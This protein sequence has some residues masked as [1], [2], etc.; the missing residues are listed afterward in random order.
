M[1]IN[2]IC[3]ICN[4]GKDIKLLDSNDFNLYLCNKCKNGFVYPI[5]NNLSDYYPKIYWQHPGR[6]SSIRNWLHDTFQKD[7][8]KWLKK[9]LSGGNILDVGSGEGVFGTFLGKEFRV[10]N[11]EAPF[12]DI[13]NKEVIKVNFLSWKTK[14]KF[15]GIVFLESLEHVINPKKYLEK[16][17]SLLKKNGY[18][19]VEYPRF[20]CFE[21]RI[22]GKYWL[23]R[24][25]PRH[26]CH[27]SESGLKFISNKV[28]LK[29][30]TQKGLIS[31]QY[32]PYCFIASV[33]RVLRIEPINFRIRS[34][35]NFVV[36]FLLMVLAPIAY[37]F[38]TIAFQIGESPVGLLVL[39]KNK[40]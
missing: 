20:S 14:Q 36:I 31:Y 27:F 28:G 22:F 35:N 25:I 13:R 21:S 38:E 17:A 40:Q 7:R 5:P 4:L 11:L 30:I 6:F 19:F 39:K 16:A 1:K 37:I 24:D 10:T 9:Y 8:I 18:I 12:A 33:M 23:N 32:S 34:L 15:D 26:L 3:P 2:I 29:A